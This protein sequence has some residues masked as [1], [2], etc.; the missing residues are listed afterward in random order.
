[1]GSQSALRRT[2][3]LLIFE[4]YFTTGAFAIRP[5]RPPKRKVAVYWGIPVNNQDLNRSP[6]RR[7]SGRF[8]RTR[9]RYLPFG[10]D[11]GG[12]H[13]LSFGGGSTGGQQ[14]PPG[15]TLTKCAPASSPAL[16]MNS[17]GTA[18]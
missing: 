8:S 3:Q 9:D 12:Q 4:G 10:D 2:M 18:S 17:A 6:Y 13:V 16:T 5:G 11:T 15:F 7:S 14:G 1:M